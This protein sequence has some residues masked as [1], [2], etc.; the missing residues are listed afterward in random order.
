MNELFAVKYDELLTEFNRYV[1]GHPQFLA[2][3]PNDA[4]IILVDPSDPEFN[5]YS[6]ERMRAYRCNDDVPDRPVIYVDI[7]ELAPVRSRLLHPRLLTRPP[8]VLATTAS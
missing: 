1:M 6:L 7:G 4:L 8:K 5:R 3:A 2:D